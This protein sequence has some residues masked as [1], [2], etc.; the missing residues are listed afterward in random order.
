MKERP[1][2]CWNQ[3]NKLAAFV[4]F[5]KIK[6]AQF[7]QA[8]ANRLQVSF[9][10]DK[11]FFYIF[12]IFRQRP[13]FFRWDSISCTNLVNEIIFPEW[14]NLARKSKT[15]FVGQNIKIFV[16]LEWSD[17]ARK[18][19]KTLAPDAICQVLTVIDCFMGAKLMVTSTDD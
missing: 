7:V 6:M 9:S 12:Y 5:H 15:F 10:S 1:N 13:H 11:K 4:L 14:S 3:T 17:S 18:S 16:L 2:N 8:V 19:I